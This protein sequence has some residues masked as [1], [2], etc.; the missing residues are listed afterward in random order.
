MTIAAKRPPSAARGDG[1]R[2][3]R[4]TSPGAHAVR[5]AVVDVETTGLDPA[6]T[7]VLECAIVVLEPDGVA[8][9][10]W[11]SLIAVPGEGELGASW[12][13]GITRSM[14][15]GAPSFAELA[16]EISRQLA[17]RVVVGHVLEF[18]L[19]HLAAEYTRCGLELPDLRRAGICTR[20]LA[21]S[22]LPPGSRS[23]AACCRALGVDFPAAHTALGDARATAAIFRAFL[24]R[25]VVGGAPGL[26]ARAAAL[27]WPQSLWEPGEPS[28]AVPRPT[29]QRRA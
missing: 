19:A 10:E 16:G 7:R 25:G 29:R 21:R 20:D 8:L 12:L 14:L 17:G 4:Q 13:H 11:T 23:L 27:A 1:S 2:P 18:D 9:G 5:Y 6:T 15:A 26:G 28:R 22:S 24:Q 3:D